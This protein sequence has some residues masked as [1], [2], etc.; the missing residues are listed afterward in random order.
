MGNRE[1]DAHA[2]DAAVAQR[3]HSAIFG[4]GET[5]ENES[6]LTFGEISKLRHLASISLYE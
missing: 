1:P 3:L 6:L 5:R 4:G 2:R